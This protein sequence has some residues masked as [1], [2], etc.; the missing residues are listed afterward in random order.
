MMTGISID[1][2][3]L[4][5]ITFFFDQIH[6]IHMMSTS[7]ISL[8]FTIFTTSICVFLF[9]FLF[10]FYKIKVKN[11]HVWRYSYLALKKVFRAFCAFQTINFSLIGK[12]QLIMKTILSF[13][14]LLFI[15]EI[16]AV[17]PFHVVSILIIML[18]R[19]INA[20]LIIFGIVFDLV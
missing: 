8:H 14:F 1:I 18:I 17:I 10:F 20:N 9:I 15:S 16:V 7:R 6:L 2:Y 13:L 4:I 12:V 19:I 5:L 11:T 3:I